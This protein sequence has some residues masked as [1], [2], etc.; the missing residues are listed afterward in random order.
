[1]KDTINFILFILSLTLI[2]YVTNIYILTIIL[3]IYISFMLLLQ[4]NIQDF[5]KKLL[6][7][8]P[9]LFI[10]ILINTLITDFFYAICII[11]RLLTAYIMSYIYVK[12]VNI[13]NTIYAIYIL[14][15]PLKLFK[16]NTKDI[17]L[18]ITIALRILPCIFDELDQKYTALKSKGYVL[19]INN[20]TILL[21]PMLV[22]LI[23]RVNEFEE[24]LYLKGYIN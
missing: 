23:L 19:K 6:M 11:V 17:S 12:K 8:T 3:L 7:L 4:L 15:T 13:N 21:K 18:I 16:I 2:F 22:S 14:L 9:F 24:A 20:I 10:T 5:L 1:M